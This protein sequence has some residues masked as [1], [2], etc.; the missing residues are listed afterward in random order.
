[1]NVLV[2]AAHPDDEVLGAGG[3]MARL[4][5]EGN[6]LAVLI[7]G[8]G[9]TSRDD[10]LRS[11]TSVTVDELLDQSRAAAAVLGVHDVKHAKMPDNRFDSVDLLSIVKLIEAEVQ[12]VEPTLVLTQHGGDVNIDHHLTYRAVLAATRPVSRHP[13]RSVLAFE[14]GSSTEWAFQTLAPRFAPQVFFDISATLDAKLEA[15]SRYTSEV[16]PFPHPRSAES[17][18]AQARRW[19]S[20]AGVMAAEA[21]QVVREIR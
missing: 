8:E 12:R 6:K 18:T 16:R 7:L 5:A 20:A 13:V 11:P 2:V 14:V 1:V 9:I 21:F 10:G 17:V 19:G 15:L 4:S 3:T